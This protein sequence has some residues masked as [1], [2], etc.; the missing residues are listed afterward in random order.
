MSPDN[1]M[2]VGDGWRRPESWQAQRCAWLWP[3]VSTEA[4]AAWLRR[5]T[6]ETDGRLR[7]EDVYANT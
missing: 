4:L 6:P 3:A 1:E 7:L 5:S 2:P